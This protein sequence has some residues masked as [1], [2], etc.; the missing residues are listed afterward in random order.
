MVGMN[1]LIIT[2]SNAHYC[3]QAYKYHYKNILSSQLTPRPEGFS[4]WSMAKTVKGFSGIDVV[5]VPNDWALFDNGKQIFDWWS[6][7]Q[8]FNEM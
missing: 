7:Y 3:R 5:F 2:A 1:I 6:N 8:L 4:I